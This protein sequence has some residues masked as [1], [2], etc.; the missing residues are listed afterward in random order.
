MLATEQELFARI[1]K[2]Y[3]CNSWGSRQIHT[4]ESENIHAVLVNFFDMFGVQAIRLA[5]GEPFIGPGV[6]STDGPYWRH[7][8]ELIKPMFARAQISDL[9]AL[10]V[11]LDHMLEKIPRDGSTVEL[12]SLL[13]MM[14]NFPAL[15]GALR[16]FRG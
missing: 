15:F 8:R 9:D 13:K 1:G 3:E 10:Q 5:V 2:T 11:H 4:M 6:F 16:T 12:Q 14:V 7:S